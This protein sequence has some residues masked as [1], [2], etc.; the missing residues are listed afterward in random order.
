MREGKPLVEP[1]NIFS[2]TFACI[3]FA[4]LAEATG[5]DEHAHMAKEIFRRILERR[6]NPK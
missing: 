3:G 1:Y 2:N 4:Q 5:N 6:T